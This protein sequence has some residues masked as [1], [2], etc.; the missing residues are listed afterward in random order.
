MLTYTKCLIQARGVPAVCVRQPGHCAF[1]V[2]DRDEW[3]LKNGACSRR[4]TFR[5]ANAHLS[6]SEPDFALLRRRRADAAPWP[7]FLQIPS[8]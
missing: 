5:H 2:R 8:S 4:E 1:L 3:V 6:W 7:E